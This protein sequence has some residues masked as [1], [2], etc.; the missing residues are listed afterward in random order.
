[1]GFETVNS[2]L[3]TWLNNATASENSTEKLVVTQPMK[4]GAYKS[5][6]R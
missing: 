1:M 6:W 5:P 3:T 4:R 2:V